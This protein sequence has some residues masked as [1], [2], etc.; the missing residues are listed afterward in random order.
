MAT[1]TDK[2]N[3]KPPSTQNNQKVPPFLKWAGG[4]SQLL[5]ELSKYIPKSYGRYIEPFLGGGA[6]FFYLQPHKAILADSNE[7]LINC[8]IVVRD[9]VEKLIKALKTYVNEEDFYYKVRAQNPA[10]L[11]EIKR[12]A[13]IIY[14][15]KTC[16][17]GLYSVNKQVQ[18]NLL[19]VDKSLHNKVLRNSNEYLRKK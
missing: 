3:L 17:N 15:N 12:S 6:L 1:I 4:K 16:Y 13:R 9:N 18:F 11:G 19:Y 14:L 8:Y 10:K 2:I 7:E 5:P